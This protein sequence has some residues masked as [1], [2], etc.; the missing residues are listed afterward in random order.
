MTVRQVHLETIDPLAAGLVGV[1]ADEHPELVGLVLLVA[2]NS[3]PALAQAIAQGLDLP[4]TKA[5]VR[6][7]AEMEIFVRVVDLGGF[8]AAARAFRLTPSAVSKLVVRLEA[9]LGA[10]L[11]NRSGATVPANFIV[12]DGFTRWVAAIADESRNATGGGVSCKLGEMKW[13][14][15]P[16]DSTCNSDRTK[17]RQVAKRRDG[18]FARAL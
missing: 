7:F 11:V 13:V 16:D 9:R 12:E 1:G 6:R 2:G 10:R 5:V 18:S 17:A 8:T 15:T 3:N 4:L 14:T